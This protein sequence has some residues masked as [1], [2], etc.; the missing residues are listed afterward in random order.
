MNWYKKVFRKYSEDSR[1]SF[2]GVRFNPGVT[3]KDTSEIHP[4]ESS[5]RSII[6][7][8]IYNGKTVGYYELIPMNNFEEERARHNLNFMGKRQDNV[9]QI[10]EDA[11][12]FRLQGIGLNEEFQ[13]PK[14]EGGLLGLGI[15]AAMWKDIF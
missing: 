10:P 8:A 5:G 4:G 3:F 13:K 2:R 6:R 11:K 15:G 1:D 7:Y 14:E 9:V 12:L